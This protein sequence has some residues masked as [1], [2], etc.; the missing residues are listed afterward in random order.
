MIRCKC[1]KKSSSAETSPIIGLSA[2]IF[3]VYIA[4]NAF[5]TFLHQFY[6]GD[7]AIFAGNSIIIFFIAALII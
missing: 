6:S 1:Y 2:D 3:M 7:P 4:L 5:S